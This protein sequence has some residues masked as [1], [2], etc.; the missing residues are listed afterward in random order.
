MW[1]RFLLAPTRVKQEVYGTVKKNKA[2][3]IHPEW[4]QTHT[5]RHTHTHTHTVFLA[6]QPEFGS[7]WVWLSLH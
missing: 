7:A 1:S 6:E 5:L 4:V 2:K 3:D